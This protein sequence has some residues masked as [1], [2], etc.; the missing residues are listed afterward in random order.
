M[1]KQ[2]VDQQEAAPSAVFL[3]F[4]ACHHSG[5]VAGS[6][7]WFGNGM[8]ARLGWQAGSL[9]GEVGSAAACLASPGK[10]PSALSRQAP[11]ILC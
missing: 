9:A 3:S 8:G 1:G 10:A 5:R 4:L 11:P 7:P 2:L 6:A